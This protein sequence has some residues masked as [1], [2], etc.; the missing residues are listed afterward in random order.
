MAARRSPERRL[1][2]ALGVLVGALD[3][4]EVSRRLLA[5]ALRVTGARAGEV[6]LLG[7]G[8]VERISA[9]RGRGRSG[10]E[11]RRPLRANG[12]TL[13]ELRLRGA[14]A[15]SD[16]L[17]RALSELA[18]AGAR[19]LESADEHARAVARAQLDSLTGLVNHGWFWVSLQ[20]E[21]ERAQRYGR[22]VSV[23]ML[24]LD[25][26]KAFNDR[27]GHRA[28]DEA[29]T[30]AAALVRE[31]SRASDTAARYGGDELALVLPETPRAGALAVAGKICASIAELSAGGE[32][33]TVSAG[34][35]TAPED[36]RGA[37]ELFRAADRRCYLA[38]SAGG[39]R[40]VADG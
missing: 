32:R 36:G 16:S 7:D 38:K 4:A 9:S 21:V 8:G 33:V 40:A 6:A 13:G 1:A 15:Q 35:A 2:D 27:L 23:V 14:G 29:L 28:G 31:R 3:T 20:R 26:F 30:R 11:L 5:G 19:A 12:R 18:K 34:V 22:A 10:S 37:D 24:D 17:R 39:N 25:G